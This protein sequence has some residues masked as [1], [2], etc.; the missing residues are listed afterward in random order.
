MKMDEIITTDH[1]LTNQKRCATL[2]SLLGVESTDRAKD[3][4]TKGSECVSEK[5]K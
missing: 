2:F 5:A 4:Y 1:L 3:K